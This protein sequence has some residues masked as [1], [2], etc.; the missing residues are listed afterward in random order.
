MEKLKCLI[1]DDEPLSR[2]VV[3]KYVEDTPGLGLA[4]QFST[5]ME[6][7][8]Y[9]CR[10]DVDIIFL[11]VRMPGLSGIQFLKSLHNPPLV[12]FTTAYPEF[13]L[14]G[15]EVDAVDYLLKPFPYERFL[16]AVYKAFEKLK[17]QN[18]ENREEQGILWLKADKRLKRIRIADIGYVEA[19]GDYVRVYTE[20][21]SL[22]VHDT[23]NA[24]YE[25]LENYGFARIHRSFIVALDKISY[26]EGNQVI[27]GER[28]LPL[29][30]M[31]KDE[32][33]RRL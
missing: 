23:M 26:I 8:D 32:F 2:E 10:N 22:I 33:L 13:A 21:D 9:L 5:A 11:D 20:K 29:G 25:K 28:V 18:S 14:E 15:F 4:G 27:L 6:A 1:V 31:F 19:L 7:G 12:I 16:K 30:Q 17:Q 3:E 24:M